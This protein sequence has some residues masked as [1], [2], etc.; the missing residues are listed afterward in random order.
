MIELYYGGDFDKARDASRTAVDV[1]TK[2]G[3]TVVRIDSNNFSPQALDEC[4]GS[5]GLFFS[6]L[7]VDLKDVCD[8]AERKEVVLER[9]NEMAASPN[10]FVWSERQL[11]VKS[12][13]EAKKHVALFKDFPAKA[14]SRPEAPAVFDFAAAVA[15]KDKKRAWSLYA[16]KIR[17]ESSPE[18]TCGT[19]VW[20]FKMIVLAHVCMT[21]DEA[22]VSPY[23]FSSAKRLATKVS[24]E[25]ALARLREV[26]SMYHEAHRGRVD[27]DAAIEQFA[28][29]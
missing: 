5:Q 15:M 20:Q 6:R 14:K 23:T 2:E 24:K 27:L 13:A 29:V 26:V 18:E 16:S 7:V 28:L 3:S 22:G 11:D 25:E 1:R 19:L 10:V 9:L 12:L 8:L 4:I 17:E 21:A